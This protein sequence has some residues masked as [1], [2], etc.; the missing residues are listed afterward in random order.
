[1]RAA[2]GM[3]RTIDR[4]RPKQLTDS[5]R[6]GVDHHPEIKLVFKTR[7]NLRALIRDRG[8]IEKVTSTALHAKYE[9]ACREYRKVRRQH[10][11]AFLKEV[12]SRYKRE[13]Q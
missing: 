11:K 4:R 7:T 3:S 12:K 9:T 13:H 6:A 10:Q 5:Q 8:G 2:S 1:M